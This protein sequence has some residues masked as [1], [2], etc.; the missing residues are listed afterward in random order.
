MKANVFLIIVSLLISALC[1]YGFY[2]ANSSETFCLL[3]AFGSGICLGITLIGT[4]GIK[5][6]SRTGNVN[7][8]VVSA[9]F[10]VLFLISNLIFSFAGVKVAP[11][12]VINGILFLIYSIIEYGI[13]KTS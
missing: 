4:L 7:F 12:I 9:I 6:E 1:G 10:F 2:A 8:R 5:V 3:L 13:V 11:Y